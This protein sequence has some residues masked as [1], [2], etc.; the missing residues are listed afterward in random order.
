MNTVSAECT[1][2]P[3]HQLSTAVTESLGQTLDSIFLLISYGPQHL[4]EVSIVSQQGSASPD[5]HATVSRQNP[6]HNNLKPQN[7]LGHRNFSAGTQVPTCCPV[8]ASCQYQLFP[9]V[10]LSH[11][12]TLQNVFS[13][14]GKSKGSRQD[15]R[16]ESSLQLLAP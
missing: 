16:K 7:M 1:D 13:R 11:C 14:N 9:I 6:P 12:G 8:P 10:D 15:E 4:T 5:C 3:Y 2:K